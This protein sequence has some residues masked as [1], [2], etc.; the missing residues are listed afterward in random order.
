MQATTSTT[1]EAASPAAVQDDGLIF[2]LGSEDAWDQA[3]VG[4]PVV[5]AR[6][7]RPMQLH[8]GP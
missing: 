2:G 3:V 7:C 8:D 1:A 6:L 5:R 4:S